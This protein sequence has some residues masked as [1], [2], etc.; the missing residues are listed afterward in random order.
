M[1]RIAERIIAAFNRLE[2]I[3]ATARDSDSINMRHSVSVLRA[4]N[5][6]LVAFNCELRV[7]VLEPLPPSQA[8]RLALLDR[9]ETLLTQLPLMI[10]AMACMRFA[11]SPPEYPNNQLVF[12]WSAP[13]THCFSA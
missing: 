4:P 2:A 13:F 3:G 11:C 1:A 10:A 12:V 9:L 7:S 6:A 5:A 8:S